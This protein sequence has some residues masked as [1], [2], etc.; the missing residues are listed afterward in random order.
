MEQHMIMS[1]ADQVSFPKLARYV[2]FELPKVAGIDVIARAYLKYAQLNRASLRRALAWGNQP[3]LVFVPMSTAHGSF[4]GG[5]FTPDIHSND[6]RINSA[7][8]TAFEAGGPPRLFT[9]HN[10][11]GTPFPLIGTSILH[12]LVHWGDD[13]DGIDFPGEE[14]NLFEIDVYGRPPLP[15]V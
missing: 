14:G 8:A 7:L 10:A 2:R 11:R 9:T 4:E 5:E 13:Q 3:T 12:E 6:L 15:G 1:H